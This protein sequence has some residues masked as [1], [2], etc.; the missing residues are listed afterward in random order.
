MHQYFAP[1]KV[2]L[3]GCFWGIALFANILLNLQHLKHKRKI[4]HNNF[5][6]PFDLSYSDS[7]WMCHC[8]SMLVSKYS[9]AKLR[10]F[11]DWSFW[12]GSTQG[13]LRIELLAWLG[14]TKSDVEVFWFDKNLPAERGCVSENLPQSLRRSQGLDS[15]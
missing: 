2:F 13:N 8:V 7:E 11:Q 3:M 15:Y 4:Q 6:Q 10:K 9:S 12:L 1:N 14:L 5:Y